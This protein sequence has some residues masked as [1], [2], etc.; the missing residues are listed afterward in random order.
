MT[1][2]TADLSAFHHFAFAKVSDGGAESLV[3]LA[4][5]WEAARALEES[6]AGIRESLADADADRLVTAE[7]AFA[8]ARQLLRRFQ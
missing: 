6:A 8:D 3:Q 2:S 4:A 5:E 1:I 7:Q